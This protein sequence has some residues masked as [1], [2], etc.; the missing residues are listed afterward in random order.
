M[1]GCNST[2]SRDV[3]NIGILI[4][5]PSLCVC[6]GYVFT[7]TNYHRFSGRVWS[8]KLNGCHWTKTQGVYI[9]L[10]PFLEALGENLFSF[11]FQL[12][13][14]A[15]ILWFVTPFS[16][17][18]A[19]HGQ[20]DFPLDVITQVLTLLNLRPIWRSQAYWISQDN[21]CFVRSTD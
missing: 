9:R 2:Y 20:S 17:F 10:C 18:K 4:E 12:L 13:E 8:L 14:V 21:L 3:L 15:Y 16:I 1:R 5:S 19:S 11:P 7:V 6:G